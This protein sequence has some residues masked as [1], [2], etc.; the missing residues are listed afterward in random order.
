MTIVAAIFLG[1]ATSA[2]AQQAAAPAAKPAESAKPAEAAKPAEPAKQAEPTKPEAAKPAE[3]TKPAQ[4][5]KPAEAAKPAETKPAE[6][7]TP[8]AQPAPAAQKAPAAPPAKNETP[9][10]VLNDEDVVSVLSQPVFSAKGENMGHVVDV[11]VDRKADIRAVIIDFGGFLGV[12]SRKV[13]VDWQALQFPA[14]GKLDHLILSLNR[15]E[16]QLAPEYKPGE[17]IVVLRGSNAAPPS[18]SAATPTT[19]AG[20]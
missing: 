16:V 3:A 7:A 19:P 18:A 12:G 17:P 20:K 10:V 14:K 5:I 2:W 1:A 6:T 8:A 13:A 15:R 11:L 9:A 4:A